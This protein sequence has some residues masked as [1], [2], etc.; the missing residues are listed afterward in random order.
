MYTYHVLSEGEEPNIKNVSLFVTCTRYLEEL[1][2][3]EL[4]A[5]GAEEIK[6]TKAGAACR[7]DLETAYRICLWSR[8]AGRVL[9]KISDFDC[10]GETDLYRGARGVD[11]GVHFTVERT[12]MVDASLVRA[13]LKN[14]NYAALKVKDAVADWFREQGGIRPSVDTAAPDIRISVHVERTHAD[15]Y[16][17]ISGE[18]LFKRGYRLEA[19]EAPLRENSAA[20]IL[21]K[22]GWNRGAS[23]GSFFLDPMC[24]SGTLLIEAGLMAA[25]SAPGLERKRWGFSAWERHDPGLW[26]GLIDEARRRRAEGLGKVPPLFGADIDPEAI[27]I[28]GENVRRAGLEGKVQLFTT[29]FRTFDCSVLPR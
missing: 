15:L 27:R 18:S 9:L 19:G 4:K 6:S 28:C 22:A 5:L 25:D 21:M 26:D 7:A 17:D 13:P 23:E 29:D 20:A 12:F 16:L 24:G 14:E 3:E 2:A 11:W 1:L 8:I 10:S